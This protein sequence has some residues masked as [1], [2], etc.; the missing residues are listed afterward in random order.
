MTV[1]NEGKLVITIDGKT[2]LLS[3]EDIVG[4]FTPKA[5]PCAKYDRDTSEA[6]KSDQEKIRMDLIPPHALTEIAKVFTFGAKKYDDWNYI[7]N[8]G[9]KL[10]RVYGALLRHMFAWF[11]G[12]AKDP[13][14]GES[15][16]AHAGCCIMM[17]LELE[18]FGTNHDKPK[19]YESKN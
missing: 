5:A 3:K 15:H 14:T 19:H 9:L 13:E 1:T 16:L 4:A 6:I 11:K 8:G 10:S 2:Q 18:E 12:E 7:K 17:L